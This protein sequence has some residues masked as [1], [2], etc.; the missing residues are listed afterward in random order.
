MNTNHLALMTFQPTLKSGSR[1]A[2][3]LHAL[4]D[5]YASGEDLDGEETEV[6]LMIQLSGLV[7]G[8]PALAGE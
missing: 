1:N 6:D 2:Q 3:A 8:A 7:G 4:M 5:F